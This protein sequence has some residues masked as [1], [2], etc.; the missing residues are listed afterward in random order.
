MAADEL[1]KGLESARH[2]AESAHKAA[3]LGDIGR[4]EKELN[5]A[6][7][8]VRNQFNLQETYGSATEHYWRQENVRRARQEYTQ[9]QQRR[10]NLR[11][12]D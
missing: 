7:V 9:F 3:G 6:N 11:T 1:K 8:A 12:G 2:H 10:G 5:T 4:A